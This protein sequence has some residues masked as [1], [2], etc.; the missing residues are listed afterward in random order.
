VRPHTLRL[1]T[2]LV[3]RIYV[4]HTVKPIKPSRSF[5][6]ASGLKTPITSVSEFIFLASNIYK[7]KKRVCKSLKISKTAIPFGG[8]SDDPLMCGKA[9]KLCIVPSL[10]LPP[11]PDRNASHKRENAIKLLLSQNVSLLLYVSLPR[12]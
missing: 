7:V 1:L 12:L 9:P 10:W 3:S 2:R 4:I 8:P 6:S 11:C 5:A